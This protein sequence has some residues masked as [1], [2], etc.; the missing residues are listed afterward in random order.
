MKFKLLVSAALASVSLGLAAPASAGGYGYGPG[1][2]VASGWGYAPPPAAHRPSYGPT[3]GP[4]YGP[5][6]RPHRHWTRDAWIPGLI[7]GGALLYSA[8]RPV[9]VAPPAP[10]VVPPA[11]P[12]AYGYI[13]RDMPPAAAPPPTTWWYWCPEARGYY[14]HVAACPSG[15]QRVPA[16]PVPY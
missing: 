9:V 3:Y 4:N 6:Y 15:W 5:R 13:E 16:Q 12:A 14:P 1:G 7:L 8:T 10:V 2:H 11:G